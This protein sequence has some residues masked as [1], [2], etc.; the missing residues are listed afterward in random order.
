MHP[1]P[2]FEN[3]LPVRARRLYPAVVRVVDE[4]LHVARCVLEPW[5]E[6]RRPAL[7]VRP[8]SAPQRPR[9]LV[10]TKPGDDHRHVVNPR[11]P[12]DRRDR[13]NEHLGRELAFD[14]G[15]S[16]HPVEAGRN[17]E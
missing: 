8:R 1:R 11:D 17:D 14:I 16:I 10:L 9:E 3:L 15:A 2:V 12:G 7:E 5:S 13:A 6:G 4:R